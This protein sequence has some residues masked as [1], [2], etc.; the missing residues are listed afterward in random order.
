MMKK[1]VSGNFKGGLWIAAGVLLAGVALMR[2]FGIY[3]ESVEQRDAY[4]SLAHDAV[5]RQGNEE[6]GAG[7]GGGEEA[8]DYQAVR[9][10]F[11]LLK[12][13]NDDIVGWILFD[14]NGISYPVLKGRDNGEYLYTMADGTKNPSGSIFIDSSCAADFTGLHTII[15]GHN[16]KDG[17]MFGRLKQYSLQEDYYEKNRYFTVY[18]PE[19]V[20]RYEIFAWYEAKEDDEVYRT[21]FLE[22]GEFD[23]FVSRMMERRYADTKN[24]ADGRDKIVTLSTCSSEGMR[25]VVH[26]KM[27]CETDLLRL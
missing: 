20:F 1:S 22:G 15:Y 3:G 27:I 17:S 4:G 9:V 14:S 10:D 25:F 21:G 23:A 12:Q 11:D 13:T 2:L 18:T 26:G 7:E 6:G 5:R 19:K 16:M 8:F 24:S